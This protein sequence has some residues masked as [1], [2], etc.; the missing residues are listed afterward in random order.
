MLHVLPPILPP[1]LISRSLSSDD[2]NN[3]VFGIL[4]LLIGIVSHGQ[5]GKSSIS[6]GVDSKI[7]VSY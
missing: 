4:A 1:I 5:C 7:I 3:I 6:K 2:E